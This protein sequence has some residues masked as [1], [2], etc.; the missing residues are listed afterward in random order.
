V[1]TWL[2]LVEHLSA[3]WYGIPLDEFAER[4]SAANFAGE[5]DQ[6]VF[7]LHAAD[8]FL[9]PVH[10]AYALQD[11]VV[12]NPNVH[13]RIHDKGAHV[14]FAAIDSS[15]YHSTLRRW[16][17]YWSTAPGDEPEDAPID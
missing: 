15:W 13:V 17:E 9:V 10:H 11:A 4:A 7:V 14:S 12:D 3:P 1:K 2:G 5:I 6:P 8:D 16:F